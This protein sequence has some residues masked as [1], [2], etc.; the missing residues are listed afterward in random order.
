MQ[1]G[2][3]KFYVTGTVRQNHLFVKTDLNFIPSLKNISHKALVNAKDLPP[4]Y[5]RLQLMKIL[6]KA[7][8]KEGEMIMYFRINFPQLRKAKIKEVVLIGP[9]IK[10]VLKDE[11]FE[12]KLNN[13]NKR[14]W[15]SFKSV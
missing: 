13:I 4:L 2:Y 10:A 5:I 1:T 9:Q 12:T 7:L 11:E 14:G 8:S 3:T 6:V 15:A